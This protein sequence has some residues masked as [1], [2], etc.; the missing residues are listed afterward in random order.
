MVLVSGPKHVSF[1]DPFQPFG[2][3]FTDRVGFFWEGGS[4]SKVKMYFFG[5]GFRIRVCFFGS[6]SKAKVFLSLDLGSG[7]GCISF[8]DSG[9]RVRVAFYGFSLTLHS[10]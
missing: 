3:S 8:I 6:G 7:P 9:Y 2:S 10:L 4:G 1:T 5:S